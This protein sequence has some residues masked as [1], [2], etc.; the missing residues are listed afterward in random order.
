MRSRDPVFMIAVAVWVDGRPVRP[1]LAMR[2]RMAINSLVGSDFAPM[3]ATVTPAVDWDA[4]QRTEREAAEA[5]LPGFL[6][7]H[8][9]I[10]TP[11]AT[12]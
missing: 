8:P 11:R 10:G 9:E 7:S 3:V 1:G 2:M 6:L 5:S 4:L 12:R